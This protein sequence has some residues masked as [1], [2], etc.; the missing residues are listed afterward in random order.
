MR[1]ARWIRHPTTAG[2]FN[3]DSRGR[4]ESWPYRFQPFSKWLISPDDVLMDL[5][6]LLHWFL[7]P[8]PGVISRDATPSSPLTWKRDLWK[9]LYNHSVFYVWKPGYVAVDDSS[10]DEIP[11]PS[12]FLRTADSQHFYGFSSHSDYTALMS[13]NGIRHPEMYRLPFRLSPMAVLYE[14]TPS[15]GYRALSS[16]VMKWMIWT[17]FIVKVHVIKAVLRFMDLLA[18]K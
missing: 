1:N 2:H 13:S 11:N 16:V 5:G 10:D 17:C 14:G 3:M 12:I 8:F 15:L 9:L 4:S 7:R 6:M 18:L